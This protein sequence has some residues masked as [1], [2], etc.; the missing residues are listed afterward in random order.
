MKHVTF[1][2]SCIDPLTEEKEKRS[3]AEG[4]RVPALELRQVVVPISIRKHAT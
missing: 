4:M 3:D 1:K 2:H